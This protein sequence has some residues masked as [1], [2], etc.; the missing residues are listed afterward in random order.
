MSK[1][2]SK[3]SM[4]RLP[5]PLGMTQLL[6][7]YH[8]LSQPDKLEAMGKIQ[9]YYINQWFLSNGSICGKSMSINELSIFLKCD[10]SKVH[11]YMKDRVLENRIWD[12]EKQEEIL[13]ALLGHQLSWLLEDRMD[14]QKQVEL[15]KES[16]GDKYAAFISSELN[17]ALKLKLDSTTALQ[18]LIKGLTASSS[19]NIFQPI[20]NNNSNHIHQGITQQQAI[21]KIQEVMAT[22]PE[23]ARDPVKYIE[24]AYDVDSFVPVLANEQ[25][26]NS[27]K[28]GLKSLR[29]DNNQIIDNYKIHTESHHEIR[30][31][32]EL[33]IDSEEDIEFEDIY[34]DDFEDEEF[35]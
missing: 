26:Y 18:S 24:Q 20:Q 10:L 30:R 34:E 16:Q 1:K 31:E 3:E 9:D 17:K 32:E 8:R 25:E 6:N 13:E 33:G 22:L 27:D 15:L 14:I 4:V 5:R 35:D 12:K 11:S 21:E 7:S 28:E 19:I 23:S 2:V 29:N